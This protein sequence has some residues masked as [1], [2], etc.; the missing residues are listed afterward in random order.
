MEHVAGL[1][2]SPLWGTIGVMNTTLKLRLSDTDRD[3]MAALA[4]LKG[5]NLSNW[6]RMTLIAAARSDADYDRA[7]RA[8]RAVIKTEES[9]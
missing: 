5:S 8:A 4:R 1:C 6:A 2:C 3:L 9:L 7:F